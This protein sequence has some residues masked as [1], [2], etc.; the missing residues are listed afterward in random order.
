MPCSHLYLIS[1]ADY[2]W[3]PSVSCTGLALVNYNL[4]GCP[5]LG[6]LHIPNHVYI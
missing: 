4:I 1:E 2:L 5:F 6:L 3:Q